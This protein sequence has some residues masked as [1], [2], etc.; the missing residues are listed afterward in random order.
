MSHSSD[1]FQKSYQ[2][3]HIRVDLLRVRFE[4]V[5]SKK[6][7]DPL[8]ESEMRTIGIKRDINAPVSLLSADEVEIDSREDIQNMAREITEEVD[9]KKAAF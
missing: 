2:S 7:W 4:N 6:M 9:Q 8:T 1:V 5:I 3:Q